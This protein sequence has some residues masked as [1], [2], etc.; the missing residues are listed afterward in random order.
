MTKSAIVPQEEPVVFIIDDDPSVREGL[1]DL[2]RSVD[3]KVETF[4]SAQE[5]LRQKHPDTPGC[6][7]LDVRLP[8]M[9]GLEFQRALMK[10][11]VDLP[12]IFISGYGDIPMSVQAMKS[13]AIEFLTK[14]LNEQALLD[15]IQAGLE[16]DR[17]RRVL[18]KSL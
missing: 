16:R 6:I 7:V 12:I 2:L 8:G 14:P 11:G 4:L 18:R 17:A 10:L 9:S 5:F 3:V 13:G 1:E 15:A